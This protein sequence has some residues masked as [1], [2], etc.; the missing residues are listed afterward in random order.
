MDIPNQ[1]WNV[2][3]A[4]RIANFQQCKIDGNSSMK[5]TDI[6][7]KLSFDQEVNKRAKPS[8]QVTHKSNFPTFCKRQDRHYGLVCAPNATR[9]M[10]LCVCNITSVCPWVSQIMHMPP[11]RGREESIDVHGAT[12]IETDTVAAPVRSSRESKKCN[13]C[14]RPLG[15]RS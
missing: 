3:I 11:K 1:T 12:T 14:V 7:N 5:A 9:L 6:Q 13:E 8:S 2:N 15:K 10:Y 4:C